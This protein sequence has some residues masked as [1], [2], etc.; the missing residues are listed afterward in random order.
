M[1]RHDP[2]R[3]AGVIL[4]GGLSRRMGGVDKALA[5]LGGKPM[6]AHVLE[7]L[8]AQTDRL[9]INANGDTNRFEWLATP[10]VA[11][12]VSGYAGPLAGVHAAM[13]WAGTSGG[14]SHVVTAAADTPFFPDDL[15]ARLR[16][17]LTGPDTIAI[18]RSQSGLHPVFALWPVHLAGGLEAW[19]NSTDTLR[20]TDWLRENDVA[21]CEFT[22]R[23]DGTDPFF[24]I[25]TPDDLAEAET[26]RQGTA[27]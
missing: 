19:L 2:D 16:Q 25:N 5:P 6:I 18:A 20:V 9:A 15:V 24:N 22:L 17:S 26:M 14:F 13:V 8:A 1:T 21:E 7:R 11:D 3:I 27:A 12:I 4:A 23:E 10:V